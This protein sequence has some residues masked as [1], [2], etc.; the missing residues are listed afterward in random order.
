M[1]EQIK[2]S[3][4]KIKLRGELFSSQLLAMSIRMG[5]HG[6]NKP[7]HVCFFWVFLKQLLSKV[8]YMFRC[9]WAE[10]LNKPESPREQS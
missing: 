1:R 3:Y 8:E 2:Y 6:L 9:I 4:L 7:K 10:T 5:M